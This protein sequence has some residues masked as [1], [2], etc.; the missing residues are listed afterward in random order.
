MKYRKQD[1]FF[2]HI[3]EIILTSE[4]L[5]QIVSFNGRLLFSRIL[6]NIIRI[7]AKESSSEV[8]QMNILAIVTY[9]RKKVKLL[10]ISACT[11]LLV[12]C[13]YSGQP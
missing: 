9:E 4:K 5:Y 10:E 8:V 1:L 13:D 2:Y 12:V 3:S 6:N 7:K 11:N